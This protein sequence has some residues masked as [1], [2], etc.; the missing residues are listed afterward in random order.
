MIESIKI[1]NI[2]KSYKDKQILK[3]ISLK[4][5]SGENLV[6]I[7]ESGSGKTTLLKLLN[8]LEKPSDGEIFIRGVNIQSQSIRELRRSLGYV[9]QQ[10]GLLPHLT[11]L[12]NLQLPHRITQGSKKPLIAYEKLIEAVKLSKEKLQA[13]P[14]ELSGGQQQRVGLAR[15]LANDPDIIL[16]DEPFSALDPLTRYQL[17]ED[18]LELPSF[19]SKTLI[20][21]THDIEEAVR[22]GD[23][24]AFLDNGEIQQIDTPYN[25]LF[26]PK[27]PSVQSF[28]GK[29]S[30][31]LKLKAT[32]LQQLDLKAGLPNPS[33]TVFEALADNS[34][35]PAVRSK[36]LESF[37][38]TEKAF[39]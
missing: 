5:N 13:Y 1:K 16:M 23:Q 38:Q 33:Q 39:Q 18:V 11:V 28:I 32:L 12:G 34:I 30:F 21:V 2:T 25:L 3:G 14:H 31:A 15:A 9:I 29:N 4:V 35:S 20:M 17:Q 10:T 24:I 26:H 7:G 19:Q 37:Y 6:L 22:L 36:I 8:G 27:T